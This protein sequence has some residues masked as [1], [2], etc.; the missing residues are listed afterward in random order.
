MPMLR[1]LIVVIQTNRMQ[2]SS[3]V[4]L[5][6]F[7]LSVDDSVAVDEFLYKHENYVASNGKIADDR[8]FN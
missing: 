5:K 4:I 1:C 6:L 2:S 8:G 7:I 3:P